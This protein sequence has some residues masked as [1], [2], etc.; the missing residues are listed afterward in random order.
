MNE[1]GHCQH[2]KIENNNTKKIFP[3]SSFKGNL[4]IFLSCFKHRRMKKKV[5]SNYAA[6]KES[7]ILKAYNSFQVE[8]MVS[9]LIFHPL[10]PPRRRDTV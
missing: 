10:L 5:F 8:N 7:N 6:K 4:P 2:M 3:C 1:L 9:L